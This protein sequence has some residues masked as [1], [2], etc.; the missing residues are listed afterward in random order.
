V[1]R[2]AAIKFRHPKDA[3]LTWSGRGRPAKWLADLIKKGHKR[4][5]FA[6]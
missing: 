6:V 2:T 4:E 3:S 1:S 5:E